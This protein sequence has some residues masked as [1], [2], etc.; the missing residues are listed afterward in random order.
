MN[1]EKQSTNLQMI[2]REVNRVGEVKKNIP[3]LRFKGY[4]DNWKHS[5]LG[6]VLSELYN[7]Q[8]PSRFR[9]ENWN[10][11]INWLT[12]GELNRDK[13][14]KTIE[15]ITRI[16]QVDA[17]LRIVPEGIFVMAITGLEAA[18][19]RGNCAILGIP[20]TLNQSCMALF[21]KENILF[22][23]FL[24]QWYKKNGEKYGLV[25]TQGT[26]QRSYNA[27]LIK[28]LPI[29]FPVYNEQKKLSIILR[30]LDHYLT[31]YQNRIEEL[32]KMKKTLLL[33]MFPKNGEAVP[34]IR[35]KGYTDA[36]EQRKLGEVGT[37]Y[38]GLSGK[39]KEDFGHGNG[40]FITYMNV[41]SNAVA[42][43]EMVEPVE[44]DDRQNKVVA[45][46][47]LFTTSSETPEEVGMSSVWLENSKNT[48]LNSFCFGYRPIIPF[49]PY[50]LAFMLRSSL[51][52][53]KITFL[54]QGISRYNISKNKMMDI[55]I[56]VPIMSE[57]HQIGEYFRNLDYLITLHQRK[58]DELKNMKKTLLQQ[59]L[60]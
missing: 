22:T 40:Q 37:T 15:K 55:E 31:L 42:S 10:G 43:S 56:P 20:T 44:I 11:D 4:E 5:E 32:Q 52:R 58:L 45:G 50:Y 6:E 53:K 7:G 38:T 19:T 46:D 54:A 48:Y 9:E 3:K 26:K 51:M 33:K 47:V 57:Q 1:S 30:S 25:Y 60:V 36:W 28:K 39:T 18:G 16:G 29:A 34:E 21:P 23:G 12:S 17:N 41:F 8:T 35:F 13:V 24:F 59:M 14:Y 2:L 27:E 49:D